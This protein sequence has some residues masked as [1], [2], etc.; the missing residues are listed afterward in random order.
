[1]PRLQSNSHSVL[2]TFPLKALSSSEPCFSSGSGPI[3]SAEVLPFI[4]EIDSLPA[5]IIS[6][7]LLVLTV[8][9]TLAFLFI[10][11]IEFP[12]A[13]FPALV[14]LTTLVIG[15]SN[16]TRSTFV[17][18]HLFDAINITIIF[19]YGVIVFS[20][21]P[22]RLPGAD[23]SNAL[24]REQDLRGADLT[25]ADLTGAILKAATLRGATLSNADLSD[26][27]LTSADLSGANLDGIKWTEI[28]SIEECNLYGVRFPPSGFLE[29]AKEQGAIK[30]E[31]EIDSTEINSDL[32]TPFGLTLLLIAFIGLMLLRKLPQTPYS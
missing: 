29:W 21:M 23:L 5:Q 27:D 26:A 1:M 14:F 6:G 4:F 11:T 10:K 17:V 9:L 15:L 28:K 22:L 13:I 16:F 30:E 31:V 12:Q 3:K 19:C 18:S 7:L 25:G 20:L 32:L 2:A 24:L 8:P